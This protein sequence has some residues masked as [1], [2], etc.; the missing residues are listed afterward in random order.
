MPAALDLSLHLHWSER[1]EPGRD[2]AQRDLSVDAVLT[3]LEIER[4]DLPCYLSA[5][6]RV[7]SA[8]GQLQ[9]LSEHC[10]AASQAEDDRQ[11]GG[12]GAGH[13]ARQT[14]QHEMPCDHLGPPSSGRTSG[15][16]ERTLTGQLR[17]KGSEIPLYLLGELPTVGRE[18]FEVTPE[19]DP[20]VMGYS[21]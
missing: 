7:G 3:G 20:G 10:T 16:D 5:A 13:G 14:R 11:G 19:V 17:K 21:G 4:A 9:L 1:A 2:V 18:D 6:Q 8:G 15:G 12:G